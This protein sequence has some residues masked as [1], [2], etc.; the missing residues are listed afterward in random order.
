MLPP[1]RFL[2]FLSHASAA[3]LSAESTVELGED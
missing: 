2:I 1:S 3:D